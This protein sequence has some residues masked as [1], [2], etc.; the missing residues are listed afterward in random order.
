MDT[1]CRDIF[2]AIHENKWL[3]I[4]YK[5]K[6]NDVTKYWIGIIDVDPVK[7]TLKV[8]GLH[9]GKYSTAELHIYIDSILSSRLID[10][11]YYEVKISLK[12]DI[13]S[14]PQKYISLF[15]HVS[16]LKIL[17]YYIDCNKLDAVPYK[18]EYSLI[19]YSV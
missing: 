16:N 8:E 15:H 4:E 14:N 10:G 13:Q 12:E 7:R 2:R 18:A 6:Q 5:N 17:N 3:D 9:L 1:I 19:D 11:S